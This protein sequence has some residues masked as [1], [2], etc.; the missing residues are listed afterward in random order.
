M[1]VVAWADREM[2]KMFGCLSCMSMSCVTL[3]LYKSLWSSSRGRFKKKNASMLL[4]WMCLSYGG[5]GLDRLG[6][7]FLEHSGLMGDVLDVY[8]IMWGEI[9]IN[10]QYFSQESRF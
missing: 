1:K 2:K 9:K 7:C 8:K 6:L 3:Q 10:V 5:G 4:G